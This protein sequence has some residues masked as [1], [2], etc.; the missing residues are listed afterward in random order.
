MG[1]DHLRQGLRS[2]ART[3]WYSLTVIIVVALSVALSSTVFA[4]VDGVLFKSLPYAHAEELFVLGGPNGGYAASVREVQEWAG[5]A[6]EAAFGVFQHVFDL[7]AIGDVRPRRI[8]A[9]G[10]DRNFFR[11]AG[12]TP[13]IGGFTPDDF[14]PTAGLV[15]ALVSYAIWQRDLGARADVVGVRLD[16][17]APVNHLGISLPGVRVAGVLPPD[18]VF[19]NPGEAADVIVPIALTP[20]HASD[21]N[22]SLASAIVRLPRGLSADVLTARVNAVVATQGFPE[23]SR[24]F[25]KGI[26]ADGLGSWLRRRVAGNFQIAFDMAM[27]LVGLA[28]INVSGLAVARRKQRSRELSVRRALGATRWQLLRVTLS[29]VLPVVA[30]GSIAGL[31]ATPIALNAVL[32]WLPAGFA[33]L[34]TPAVDWRVVTFAVVAAGITIAASCVAELRVLSDRAIA[35]RVGRGRSVTLQRGRF[36]TALIALQI[37]MAS[38]L[39]VAGSV[40]VGSLWLAWQQ[41]PGYNVDHTVVLDFS[42]GGGPAPDRFARVNAFMDTCRRIPGVE[43]VGVIGAKLLTLSVQFAGIRP[44]QGAQRVDVQS[45]PVGGDFFTMLGLQAIEGR[46]PSAQEFTPGARTVVLSERVARAY[47][48]GRPAAGQLL[49]GN[50]PGVTWTVVGVVRDARYL[51]LTSSRHGQIYIPYL[52][53]PNSTMLVRTTSTS[54]TFRAA[55]TAARQVGSGFGVTRAVTMTEA[56]GESV[57]INMFGGWLFGGFAIAALAITSVGILGVIAMSTARRT[58]ELGVR[59]ALGA[60]RAAVV[61]LILQEQFASVAAGL[62]AGA[63]V[64][65]WA[66]TFLRTYLYQFTVYDPRLWSIAG[67]IVLL[68]ALAGALVPAIRASRVDPIASLRAE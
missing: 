14:E 57:G 63:L 29:E 22:W 66:V 30:V 62:C 10:V 7:G 39:T 2:L 52:V 33:L 56:L 50:Q 12:I 43:Q 51:S 35:I 6:P 65:R 31:V 37:A 26:N 28:C 36:G 68:A 8:R 34:K 19:P 67:G 21:R 45:M 49:E 24:G 13:I 3:P 64:A 17:V 54:D 58:Q 44:P 41:D 32:R 53:S 18:F 16:V 42:P 59:V 25:S 46:L 11:V 4:I 15:P 5:A 23:P 40:V 47:W 20:E 9:G 55:L 60:T 48:P 1:I 38:V 27:V 61:R